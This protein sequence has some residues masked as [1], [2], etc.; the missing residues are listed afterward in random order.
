M[1]WFSGMTLL[2]NV[3]ADANYYLCMHHAQIDL[4]LLA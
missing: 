4:S 2:E 3:H 1:Q